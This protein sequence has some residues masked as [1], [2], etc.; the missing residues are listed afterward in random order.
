[1]ETSVTKFNA[2]YIS[3]IR[4]QQNN[5]LQAQVNKISTKNCLVS[6]ILTTGASMCLETKKLNRK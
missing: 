2:L 5:R 4:R 1:M 6:L 3:Q